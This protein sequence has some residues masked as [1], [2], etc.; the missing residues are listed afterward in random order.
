M[1]EGSR[2]AGPYAQPRTNASIAAPGTLVPHL[3]GPAAALR[4][5]LAAHAVRRCPHVIEIGGAGLPIT[6]F[7]HHR[8]ASVTVIDPKIPAFAAETLNGAPCR[9]RHLAAKLQQVALT[10]PAEAFA[11]V[12]L[13]LSLKPFGRSAA[14]PQDLLAL[15]RTAAVLVI[16]YAFALDRAQDQID[17][18]LAARDDPP[19]IDL[20]LRINDAGLARTGYGRR[21][22]LAFGAS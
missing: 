12:L 8:P 13:G 14:V 20:E 18:L 9:V 2:A 5:V 11:L 21:R 1:S 4:Q 7:L 22:W 6:G 15:A 17:A 3:S 10:P 19:T 16:D